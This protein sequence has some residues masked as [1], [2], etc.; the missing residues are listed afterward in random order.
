MELI[1]LPFI[2]N[3]SNYRSTANRNRSDVW[4]CDL[5]YPGRT[6]PGNSYNTES[7]PS[8]PFFLAAGVR[9]SCVSDHGHSSEPQLPQEADLHAEHP[10]AGG[11]D[12]C[13]E[14]LQPPSPPHAGEGPPRGDQERFLHVDR[15]HCPRP[16]GGSMDSDTATLLRRGPQGT[17]SRCAS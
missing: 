9:R 2:I 13:Q 10:T 12:G 4:K 7:P 8:R 3:F 14:L 16:A 1:S 5:C 17:A 15:A 6:A 11:R